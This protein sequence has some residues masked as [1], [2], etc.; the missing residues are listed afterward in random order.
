[1]AE[2]KRIDERGWRRWRDRIR[3]RPII[4]PRWVAG[5]LDNLVVLVVSLVLL[6]LVG[7]GLAYY[8]YRF[9]R[10]I[11]TKPVSPDTN[12]APERK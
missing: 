2:G 6:S 8:V 4:R 7:A 5:P 10:Q 11:V 9:E 1:M 12:L 3:R